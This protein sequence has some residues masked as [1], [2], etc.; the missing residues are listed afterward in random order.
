MYSLVSVLFVDF[1]EYKKCTRTCI[2]ICL[3][4]FTSY[5]LCCFVDFHHQMLCEKEIKSG[6]Q[7]ASLGAKWD[8]LGDP[9][10]MVILPSLKLAASLHL[11][12]GWLEYVS[13]P[14]GA[15]GLFSGA[16]AVRFRVMYQCN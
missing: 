1:N 12:T 7:G 14:F 4:M 13:F 2:Y 3:Y 16:L 9:N 15:N 10:A 6:S 5:F 8:H 11:E